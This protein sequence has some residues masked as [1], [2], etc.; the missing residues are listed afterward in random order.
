MVLHSVQLFGDRQQHYKMAML[1]Y[2]Q[3]MSNS[4]RMMELTQHVV[5]HQGGPTETK[6]DE[7]IPVITKY[8]LKLQ[9]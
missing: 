9:G 7:H 1:N 2:D 5:D 4:A 6:T 3:Q 8:K